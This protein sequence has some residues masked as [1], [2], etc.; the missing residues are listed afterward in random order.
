M[1]FALFFTAYLFCIK[2]VSSQVVIPDE[3]TS[4]LYNKEGVIF[5]S[6]TVIYFRL[7][8]Y[9]SHKF[10]PEVD[11]VLMAERIFIDKYKL[12]GIGHSSKKKK[13]IKK[14]YRNY[15]RQ[16][17]GFVTFSGKKIVLIQLLNFDITD[18]QLKNVYKDFHSR[19]II[20]AG[21]FFERNCVIVLVDLNKESVSS[22]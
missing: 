1:R 10:T 2:S 18:A 8:A 19:F 5:D 22:F 9:V 16:Y 11:D 12:P 6:A 4:K 3:I 21:E 15:G 13:S 20:G 14:M 7:P 17:L